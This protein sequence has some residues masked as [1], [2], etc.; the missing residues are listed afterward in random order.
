MDYDLPASDDDVAAAVEHYIEVRQAIEREAGDWG[1]LADLFTEDCVWSDV[2]WGRVEGRENVR[3]FLRKAMV[4][5]DTANPIDFWANDGPR[6]VIKWRQQF[7]GSK[8]DGR[9]W[10]QSAVTTLLY[11]GDGL[12]RYEEDL[13]NMAHCTEDVIA[14]GWLPGDGFAVPPDAPDRDFDPHPR[15]A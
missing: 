1:D 10:E 9:P 8:P 12:F 2:A 11:A 3:A 7:P 6:V 5:V 13:M 4:G 14:S 15:R